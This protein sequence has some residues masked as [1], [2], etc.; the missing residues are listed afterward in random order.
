MR[1]DVRQTAADGTWDDWEVA[2]G[3]I[4]DKMVEAAVAAHNFE[5]GDSARAVLFTAWD[6]SQT[7]YAV[8]GDDDDD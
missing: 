8:I 5:L 1:L 6:G 2:E 4:L 3:D 7:E